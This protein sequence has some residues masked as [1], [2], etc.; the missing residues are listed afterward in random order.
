MHQTGECKNNKNTIFFAERY[1]NLIQTY[2]TSMAENCKT[3]Y[4][5]LGP[6]E[7]KGV[8]YGPIEKERHVNNHCHMTTLAASLIGEMT[9]CCQKMVGSRK[10]NS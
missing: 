1:H 5:S 8:T 7:R 2:I 6:R 10:E 4:G 3:K 9:D